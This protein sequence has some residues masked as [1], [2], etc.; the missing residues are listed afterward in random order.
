[1]DDGLETITFRPCILANEIRNEETHICAVAIGGFCIVAFQY[2]S[3][4]SNLI[5]DI[6]SFLDVAEVIVGF[7]NDV[8]CLQY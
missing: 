3:G 8:Y 6:D 2:I 1:M 5:S 4:H 7:V